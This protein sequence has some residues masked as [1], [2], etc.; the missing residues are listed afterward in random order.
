MCIN[1]KHKSFWTIPSDIS[2]DID[3]FASQSGHRGNASLSILSKFSLFFSPQILAIFIYR[4]SHFFYVNQFRFL[5]Y[6]FKF[7]NMSLF[8]IDMSPASC[9]GHSLFIPHPGSIIFYGKAGHHCTLFAN[10]ACVPDLNDSIENESFFPVFGDYVQ[11]GTY[12][13]VRGNIKVK[14]NSKV[15]FQTYLYKDVPENSIA[16]SPTRT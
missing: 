6:F 3:E 2:K 1:N 7:I 12:S 11:V 14:Q 10:C 16:I 5:A 13:I 9:V 8:K 4:L 15:S